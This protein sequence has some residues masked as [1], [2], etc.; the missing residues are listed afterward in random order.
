MA[1]RKIIKINDDK[2][3]GCGLCI[4]N[5]PEGAMQM[6]DGKARLISDL[7]CDG[8]GACI[9]HCPEGA[10]TIE[11]REA[12]EY[13]E[14]KV[15]ANI[16]KQGKN[17]IIAHLK[18]LKEH[19]QTRYF[20][21]AIEFLKENNIDVPKEIISSVQGPLPCGCPGTMVKDFRPEKKSEK[22]TEKTI[23]SR[24]ELRQWPVQIML[25]PTAASY[26]NNSD[27]LIAAD[28]VPFAYAD[29]HSDLLKGKVLLVGC[30]KLDDIEVYK[31][32][33]TQIFK[34]NDIKSVTYAHM[35]VP[36][37]FGFVNIIKSAIDSCNKEIPFQEVVI[38]MKGERL[39]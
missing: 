2:C 13:D 5:C 19:S 27:L 12:E 35:E 6:I 32:K 30:P 23:P 16:A 31:E 33:I 26:L 36:C 15:M 17:V 39:K 24:S 38:S 11:E 28:C 29:F 9:G 18:H 3:T 8:L 10:I 14:R 7:F 22:Q 1:K 37:C 20:N 21:Q 4:P 34:E 25:V